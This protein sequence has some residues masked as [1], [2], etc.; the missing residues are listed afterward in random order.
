MPP[1][2]IDDRGFMICPNGLKAAYASINCAS[3]CCSSNQL[4]QAIGSGKNKWWASFAR[5][6]S[7][8]VYLNGRLLQ[9]IAWRQET[10]PIISYGA[11]INASHH[12]FP[13]LCNSIA[14]RSCS[15]LFHGVLLLYAMDWLQGILRCGCSA[16]KE[17][18]FTSTLPSFKP[19]PHRVGH[20][21]CPLQDHCS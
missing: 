3:P 15:G 12:H 17:S 1:H 8:V 16:T 21:L 6:S 13:M 14:K 5:P 7:A 10:F 2:T 18:F 11:L 9:L 19:A 4:R 20:S